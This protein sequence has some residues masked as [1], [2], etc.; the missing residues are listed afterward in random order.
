[1]SKI[2]I[3]GASGFVGTNLIPYLTERNLEIIPFSRKNR[4]SYDC[5]TSEYIKIEDIDTIV[6]LAG[7][8]HDLRKSVNPQEY[9]EINTRLTTQL[10]ETFLKSSAR[11]FIYISSIKAIADS[12][13]FPLTED[14]LPDPLTDYGKS[15]LA[16][17]QYLL[18]QSL[19]ADKRIIILR[20]CMIH[21]T[22]NKGN[23]N[24]LYQI[25]RKGIPYPLAAF[26]N[27]RS[28]LSIE[29]LCFAIYELIIRRD[30][31]SGVYNI[32]DD[33]SISTTE[34]IKM[35]SDSLGRSEKLLKIPKNLIRLI[36]SVGDILP[37]PLNNERLQKMTEDYL[38]NNEKLKK[39]IQKPFPV[40]AV[41][42]FK[43][44]IES[45]KNIL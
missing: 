27:R 26:D 20:P 44:T 14:I 33:E 3:T 30:I 1:M 23:L 45:F 21:G 25:V 19:L 18:S 10:F 37:L 38:V 2:L 17:E 28:F 13:E 34:I 35:M 8:A 40:N 36:A 9:F 22:G 41:D 24:L 11:T 42:G 29:N 7:K 32:C 16:A 39:V 31:N 43:K 4:G 12:T 6:H 5:I 15:K